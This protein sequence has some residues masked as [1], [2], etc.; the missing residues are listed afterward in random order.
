MAEGA[1][2]GD[3][4]GITADTIITIHPIGT[5]MDI[6]LIRGTVIIILITVITIRRFI[7]IRLIRMGLLTA[8]R[9]ITTVKDIHIRTEA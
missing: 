8:I 7:I 5:A 9:V 3:I 4:T 6:I 1:T 2:T